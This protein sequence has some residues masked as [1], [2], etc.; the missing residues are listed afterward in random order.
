MKTLT[1]ERLR[2]GHVA[3]YCGVY[4]VVFRGLT[5]MVMRAPLEEGHSI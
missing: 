3:Y 4:V 2:T 1:V 5:M